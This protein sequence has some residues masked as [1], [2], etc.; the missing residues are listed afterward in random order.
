MESSFDVNIYIYVAW[1][2]MGV[3]IYN[4][5][6][7]YDTTTIANLGNKNSPLDARHNFRP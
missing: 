4:L 6:I 5:V 7:Y 1:C 2:G 3:V